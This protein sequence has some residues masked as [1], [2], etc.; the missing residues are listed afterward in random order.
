MTAANLCHNTGSDLETV[1]LDLDEGKEKAVE[2][3]GK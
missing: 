3:E 2:P 1:A